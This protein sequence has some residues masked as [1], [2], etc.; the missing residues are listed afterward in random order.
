V[1]RYTVTNNKTNK[2][3]HVTANNVAHAM[4]V[5]RQGAAAICQE[6]DDDSFRWRNHGAD[7]D[8]GGYVGYSVECKG[9]HVVP[10]FAPHKKI[11]KVR[12]PPGMR[13]MN[14]YPIFE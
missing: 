11:K 5:A 1:A 3:M 9:Q 10:G 14:P 2:V 4:R 13:A 12:T 6:H 8:T 7:P